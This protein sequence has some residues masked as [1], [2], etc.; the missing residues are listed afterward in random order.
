MQQNSDT[1]R[2][3]TENVTALEIAME[4]IRASHLLLSITMLHGQHG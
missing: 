3:R 4:C 1:Q 2:L